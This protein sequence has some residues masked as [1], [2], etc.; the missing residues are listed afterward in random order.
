LKNSSITVADDTT[1]TCAGGVHTPAVIAS[2]AIYTDVIRTGIDPADEASIQVRARQ[3]K[4][5]DG[6]VM[7][8]WS[9]G[10]AMGASGSFTSNDGKTITVVNGLITAITP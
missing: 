9:S 6:T 5:A 2:S 8:D 4:K 1:V 3:L 7:L 10:A